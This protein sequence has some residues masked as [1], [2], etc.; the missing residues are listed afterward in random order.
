M[1]KKTMRT[2]NSLIVLS[3]LLIGSIIYP[4]LLNPSSKAS[5]SSQTDVES[6]PALPA[7]ALSTQLKTIDGKDFKLSELK[8]KVLLINLWATWVGPSRYEIPELVKIQSEYRERGLEVIG[9]D[10]DPDSDTQQDVQGFIKKFK[11]NYKVAFAERSLA[12][13][14]MKGGNIPQSLVVSRDG[15]I[16]KHFIGFNSTRTPTLMRQAIEQA[17]AI[18]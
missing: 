14:L 8:D 18:R 2:F 9:L 13:S 4:D 5:Q 10:V 17:L 16:I 3:V 1:E 12:T 7:S 6:L 15:K 11:V